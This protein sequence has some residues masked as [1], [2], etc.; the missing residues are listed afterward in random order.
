[1][2][3]LLINFIILLLFM[4]YY[5]FFNFFIFIFIKKLVFFLGGCNFFFFLV[6]KSLKIIRIRR[7]M[8][9]GGFNFGMSPLINTEKVIDSCA[10]D[11]FFTLEDI[12]ILMYGSKCF[13]QFSFFFFLNFSINM[14]ENTNCRGGL[15]SFMSKGWID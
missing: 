2:Y 8:T 13:L 4:V 15:W 5:N 3:N 7:A 6:A 11:V 12:K 10:H 9:Y 1:M 14:P